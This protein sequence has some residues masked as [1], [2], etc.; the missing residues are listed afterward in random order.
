MARRRTSR[1]RESPTPSG[2]SSP[3]RSCS[4]TASGGPTRPSACAPLF[5]RRTRW[6]ASS[7]PRNSA[8]RSSE[9]CRSDARRVRRLEGRDLVLVLEG[10]VDVV[11]PLQKALALEGV[12]LEG[13]RAGGL[14]L[15]VDR[16]LAAILHERLHLLLR[17]DDGDEADLHAVRAEDVAERRRHDRLEPVLLQAPGRML[18]RGATAEVPP[19][20]EDL[21]ALR[22]RSVELEVRVLRPVEEEE[23]GEARAF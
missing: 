2:Y 8:T 4:S 18:A 5:G 19:G 23:L 9:S 21:R 14:S 11:E 22:F 13:V 3:P 20:E 17:Q 16:D 6:T 12:E 10:A 1:A 7:A 15:E